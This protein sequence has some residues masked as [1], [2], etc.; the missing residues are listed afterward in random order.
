MVVWD[1]KNIKILDINGQLISHVPEFDDD[2]RIAL[3]CL[4][5]DHM[6]VISQTGGK[7]KLSL[8]DVSDPFFFFKG[9]LN[10]I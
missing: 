6:A 8:W 1:N 4:S 2:E 7:E 10:C 3:C 5:G 9:I